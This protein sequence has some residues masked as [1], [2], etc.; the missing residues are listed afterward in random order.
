MLAQYIR[1]T[2]PQPQHADYT[3]SPAP[4]TAVSK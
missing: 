3:C 4:A 2:V 1:D